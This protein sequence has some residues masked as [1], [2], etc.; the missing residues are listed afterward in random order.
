MVSREEAVAIA[1]SWIDTPRVF[2]G[3]IK[4]AGCDCGTFLEQW[5]FECAFVTVDQLPNLSSKGVYADDWFCHTK[6]EIYYNEISKFARPVWTGRC[7]GMVPAKPGDVAL[8][9][10]VG[11]PIY[12]HGCIVTAW[13]RAIHA[14]R[15][16][17]RENRPTLYPLTAHQEMVIFD[18]WERPC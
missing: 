15:E 6:E 2:G 5:A 14:H 4:G 1:R 10:V 13:P 16:G 3:R 12:N 8:F 18:P 17:V 9:R 11:S 7:F